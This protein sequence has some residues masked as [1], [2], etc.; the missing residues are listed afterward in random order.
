MKI[1]IRQ[2]GNFIQ[3]TQTSTHPPQ[4][5]K[6]FSSLNAREEKNKTKAN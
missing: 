5:L 3:Q 4:R 1:T 2:A 6:P